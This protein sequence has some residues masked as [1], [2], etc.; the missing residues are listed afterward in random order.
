MANFKDVAKSAYFVDKSLMLQDLVSE[1][2][3]YICLSRPRRFGKTVT[4]NMI[5]AFFSKG[6]DN[7]KIFDKLAISGSP[8]Y[9]EFI[10]SCNVI[11]IMM[12]D[13]PGDCNSYSAYCNYIVESL[14]DDLTDAYPQAKKKE[15]DPIWDILEKINQITGEEFVFVLDEWD[16][17]FH[18]QYATD[19]DKQSHI[20]FLRL[21]L[22]D[23]PYV[24]LAYMTGVLPVACSAGSDLNMFI[25]LS[26][27]DDY[28]SSAFGFTED[29]VD[30]LY[31]RY[32]SKP[33]VLS[34]SRDSLRKRYSGYIY[35]SGASYYN[36]YSV[37]SALAFNMAKSYWAKSGPFN[38]IFNFVQC[39][40]DEVRD[41]IAL[42]MT[43]ERVP[44]DFSNAAISQSIPATRND[45]L[46]TMA[47]YGY[48][49]YYEGE[50][51]IP[52]DELMLQYVVMLLRESSLGYAHQLAQDS[53]R[54]LEAT[55]AMDTAAICS[56]LKSAHNS[57]SPILDCNN[58][59]E[60]AA[61]VNL[62]YLADRN[63]YDGVREDKA[64]KGFAD[65]LFYPFDR[66]KECIVLE[67]KVD[68]TPEEALKQIKDKQYVLSFRG[69]LVSKPRFTG[70][71]IA[72]GISYSKDT[73]EHGSKIELL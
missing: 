65:F 63:K 22:K 29:E 4:A 37:L 2:N 44:A 23:R 25:D 31:V 7:R 71:V 28:L 49:G 27:M 58:E 42:L 41:T 45:I 34:V 8:I 32:Q 30:D 1:D 50:I 36:P 56:R 15:N 16:Y 53:Q 6:C 24:K 62:A 59:I 68:S 73:K 55:L 48:L 43:G 51:F 3:R 9:D 21:L 60:L 46:Y 38:Q 11:H 70:K 64:G 12:S 13:E 66:N 40:V 18:K 61:I 10:G 17:I 72:V 69:G 67:L 57:E 54:I 19:T 33:K 35:P 52:N 14:M 5:T 39:S 26:I 20:N 47:I